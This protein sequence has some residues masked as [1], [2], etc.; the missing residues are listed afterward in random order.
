MFPSQAILEA[1]YQIHA[2]INKY[3]EG[4]NRTKKQ[5]KVTSMAPTPVTPLSVIEI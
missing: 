1:R 5:I 4:G 3:I 2:V